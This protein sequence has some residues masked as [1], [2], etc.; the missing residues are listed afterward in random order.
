M[1]VNEVKGQILSM[2][3]SSWTMV[4]DK[5][6]RYSFDGTTLNT[7]TLAY[8]TGSA[9]ESNIYTTNNYAQFFDMYENS[10]PYYITFT[11]SLLGS[12]FKVTGT[13][14]S[15]VES[16]AATTIANRMLNVSGGPIYFRYN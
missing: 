3:S 14:Y 1:S 12:P 5:T 4:D 6:I 10:D 15:D 2:I 8:T 13:S 16:Q 7:K 11:G 9:G